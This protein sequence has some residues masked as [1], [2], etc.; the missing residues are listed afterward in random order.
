MWWG[1]LAADLYAVAQGRA[2]CGLWIV[3]LSA[4]ASARADCGL[5]GE[6]TTDHPQPPSPEAMAGQGLRRWTQP[7]GPLFNMGRVVLAEKQ[8]DRPTL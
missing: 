8:K 3:D 5:N 7:E 6:T 2:D 4:V 1:I